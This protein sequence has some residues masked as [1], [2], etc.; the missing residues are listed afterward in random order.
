MST[1][2]TMSLTI[3][4]AF[5]KSLSLNLLKKFSSYPEQFCNI[6]ETYKVLKSLKLNN[7]R[8][9]D[10]KKN[11]FCGM[12]VNLEVLTLFLCNLANDKDLFNNF[13]NLKYLNIYACKKIS[14]TALEQC[15]QNN[16]SIVSFDSLDET[17]THQHLHILP[18]LEQLR[19]NYNS[20]RMDLS[21]L[22]LRKLH[23]SCQ[24]DCLQANR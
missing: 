7:F 14:E 19:I 4:I 21:F 6:Q 11:P 12:S 23:V 22:S 18:N 9:N 1:Y 2:C 16:Q 13:T 15:F 17:L 20:R 10:F 24:C 8:R 5:V 3:W